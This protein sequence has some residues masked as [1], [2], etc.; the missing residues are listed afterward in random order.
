MKGK[1]LWVGLALLIFI[2]ILSIGSMTGFFPFINP[3]TQFFVFV[4][5][6]VII[7][8]L[9]IIG[10]AFLG[11]VVSHRLLSSYTFTP[12]EKEMLKMKR[13]VEQIRKDMEEMKASLEKIS[14]KNQ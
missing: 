9:A 5:F 13:D 11:M 2:A 4:F 10:A 3:F 8:V 1:Y 14:G 7:A 6:L 12:F